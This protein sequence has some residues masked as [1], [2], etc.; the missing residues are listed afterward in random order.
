MKTGSIYSEIKGTG[1]A[2]VFIHG[3]TLDHRIWNEQVKLFSR[4]YQT[5][6][7]DMRGFGKS[8]VPHK[9]YSHHNDLR[10]ILEF[11]KIKKAHIVGLSLGGEVA[12]D[13]TLTYP[14]FVLSLVIADSS[15]GGYA[16]TVDWR[17]F[18]KEQGIDKAKKNWMNHEVFKTTW[19]NSTVLKELETIVSGYSGWHWL[20]ND[21]KE[22]LSMPALSRL[23][24]ILVPTL[25]ITGEND[26][27]YFQTIADILHKGIKNSQK[28][29]IIG[30]GH[31]S[32]MEKPEEFNRILWD[33]IEGRTLKGATL[34]IISL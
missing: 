25:I 19:E 11:N 7:Y 33:F 24:E 16:S 18:A 12:I 13:F 15:L 4:N 21:M 20:N 28:K 9:P 34:G 23:Q 17:V 6:S 29:I 30:A 26:L 1:D 3:F 22:K 31:M 5:L 27:P 2:I 8:L 32:N 14:E 10:D